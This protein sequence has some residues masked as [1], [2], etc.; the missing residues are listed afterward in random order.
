MHGDRITVVAPPQGFIATGEKV[1]V[2]IDQVALLASCTSKLS[3]SVVMAAVVDVFVANRLFAYVASG[4]VDNMDVANGYCN[5]PVVSSPWLYS[6]VVE[7][8]VRR[9]YPL[10]SV[11]RRWTTTYSETGCTHTQVQV[12]ISL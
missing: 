8:T 3:C 12:L 1:V 4:T 6:P 5:I 7:W 2:E 11:A 10:C 9:A